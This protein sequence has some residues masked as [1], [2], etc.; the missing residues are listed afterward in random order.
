MNAPDLA[1]EPRGLFIGGEW[2]AARSGRTI[3][4]I[5][6]AN[7]EVLG[8]VPLADERDVDRAVAAARAAFPAWAALPVTGRADC[9]RRLA[10]AVEGNAGSLALMDAVD[11]GNAISGMRGDMAWTADA[12]RYFAGL[13][14]EMKGQT[15]SREQGHLNLTLRQPYGVV[16]RINP[17]NHPFRFCAEKA[18]SALA[19]GNTVVIKGPEQAPLSSLRLGE[20]CA[21]IFPPGVV[22]IVT[23]D[24]ATGSA[25]VR[26]RDVARVGFVGSVET[27]RRVAREAAE[28][29]KEVTLELGGKNPIVI[30][31]DADPAKAAAQAVAA[32]NMNRQGQSC[33]STSRVL[34]HRSL[35]ERVSAELVK[36]ASSIPIGLPWLEDAEMGPIVSR[37]QYERVLRY[38]ASGREEGA[39]LLTGG[40]PPTAPE[41]ASGFFIEPTVFDRVRPEMRIGSE[42]IFGPV[43][44]IMSWSDFDEMIEVA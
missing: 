14:T 25:M 1:F 41:L 29:L 39:E 13:V 21:E 19:A 8:A 36:A 24:G 11:S 30:F 26:H 16:A 40:G 3:T 15:M 32:M 18:A 2:T 28:S 38:V 6:P 31:P 7:G 43:M 35:H 27:G 12:L 17:F 4:S 5:N 33:S 23:G 9:L 22:N 20:L 44:A 37:P 34:V 10:D 42:E